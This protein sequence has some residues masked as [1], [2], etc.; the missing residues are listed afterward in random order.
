MHRFVPCRGAKR[1][2]LLKRGLWLVTA[3]LVPAMLAGPAFA[4]VSAVDAT[5]H[6]VTL[7]QPAERIVALTPHLVENL[8]TAGLGDRVVGAVRYS[9][10][11]P[12]A[13]SIPRVGGYR[14][15]S[16]EAIL[17]RRPDLVVAWAPASEGDLVAR[18]R[19]LGIPVYV[20]DPSA[21][22]DIATT[23]RDL[24]RL[25]GQAKTGARAAAR[26]LARMQALED[27]YSARAPVSVFYV[28]ATEPLITIG[29]ASMIGAALRLCGGRN[30]FEDADVA[31][32]RIGIESLIA[33]DPAAIVTTRRDDDDD[34][35]RD[36]FWRRYDTLSAVRHDRFIRL[37]RDAISRPTVRMAGASQALCTGL[38]RVRQ[39]VSP[40]PAT[41]PRP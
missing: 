10:Y 34:P 22:A 31:A 20:D 26:F 8:F 16:L 13:T 4:G 25:G 17:A 41:A 39:A 32:P 6:R 40:A 37:A 18:L 21:F 36:V 7:D 35:A 11:P 15:V 1:Q 23:L 24:G 14:S 9:D 3:L 28:V 27:R 33:R 12:A 30:V 2:R 38:D 29:G 19:A 5:G